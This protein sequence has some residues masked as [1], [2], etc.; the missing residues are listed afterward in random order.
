MPKLS[1]WSKKPPVSDA[2]RALP[3]EVL[4]NSEPRRTR[5]RQLGALVSVPHSFFS[6]LYRAPLLSFTRYVQQ[7]PAPETDHHTYPGGLLDH[8]L[9]VVVT[10]LSLRRGYLLPPGAQPEIVS[11]KQDLWTYAV[12][13]AALL[14]DIGQVAVEQRVTIVDKRGHATGDWDVWQGPMDKGMW[15]RVS[16]V[17]DRNRIS[18]EPVAP[19]FAPLILPADALSWL[20]SDADVLSCWLG[21]LTGAQERAGVLGDIVNRADA[22]S[23]ANDLKVEVPGTKDVNIEMKPTVPHQPLTANA[24]SNPKTTNID[25]RSDLEH[26]FLGWLRNMVCAGK[27]PVNDMNARIHT[28]PEGVLL[29]SPAVFKDFTAKRADVDDWSSVQKRFQKLRVHR[30]THDG[31]NIHRYELTGS[32]K[33]AGINGLLIPDPA[34]I[35]GDRPPPPP[36]PRLQ[37]H[38]S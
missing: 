2:L 34:V 10:A 9:D 11:R 35:F 6:H 22:A 3:A 28:V 27:I 36:N 29:V 23:I 5:L 16:L 8:V 32:R 25:Q 13:A 20:A 12:F 7:L 31:A 24:A 33:R 19:L 18:R 38:V 21:V 26:D 1:F 30:K 17:R 37:L 15:Y 4:L 14:R